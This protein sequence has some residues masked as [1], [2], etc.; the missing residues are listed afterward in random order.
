LVVDGQ[1]HALAGSNSVKEPSALSGK[2]AEWTPELF[3]TRWQTEKK[4]TIPPGIKPRWH[5]PYPV[6]LPTH[7]CL[8]DFKM[9]PNQA[10]FQNNV[11][12]Y[13]TSLQKMC[14][15]LCPHRK[16]DPILLTTLL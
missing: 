1:H 6:T 2:E 7:A 4:K 8:Y 5:S 16:Y 15:I 13:A 11:I 9:V 10:Q 14:K 3:W 12:P